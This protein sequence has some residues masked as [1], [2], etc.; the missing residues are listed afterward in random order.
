[1]T[2]WMMLAA[3]VTLA[4]CGAGPDM[5]LKCDG[6]VSGAFMSTFAR[7]TGFD[8]LY[9]QNQDRFALSLAYEEG[10]A[11][12]GLEYAVNATTEGQGEPRTDRAIEPECSVT[13]TQGAKK[14][15]AT[16][17]VTG[18]TSG[19]CTLRY[20]EVVSWQQTGNTISYC[21]LRGRLDA[22]LVEDP[23]KV[24]SVNVNLRIDFDYAPSVAGDDPDKQRALCPTPP[25]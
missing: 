25:M 9:R 8:Q 22:Q 14:W 2:R 6:T 5:K 4:G 23:P 1:M 16:R 19:A 7:C 17:G 12:P 24:D 18:V 21:I 3:L 15:L 10:S 13:V 11:T 20:S